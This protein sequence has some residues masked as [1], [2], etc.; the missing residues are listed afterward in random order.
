MRRRPGLYA[1]H[2][3]ERGDESRVEAYKV[4]VREF[5][6]T[7]M[8]GQAPADDEDI[9]ETGYVNSLFAM[10]LITFI[11][12]SFDVVVDNEDLELEN[13]SSVDRIAALIHGKRAVR[14]S[15]GAQ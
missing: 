13:F 7:E 1:A 8:G 12:G 14:A 4:A 15:S 6:A 10:E 3:F 11:E 9:F 5:L 2:L